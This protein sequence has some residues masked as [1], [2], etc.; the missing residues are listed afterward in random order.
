MYSFAFYCILKTKVT[1]ASYPARENKHLGLGKQ[2]NGH[3][4]WRDD[5][6]WRE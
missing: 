5:N 2:F 3:I 1:P 4:N 6:E